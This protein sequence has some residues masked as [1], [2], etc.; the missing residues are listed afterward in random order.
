M[1]GKSKLHDIEFIDPRNL[2][3]KLPHDVKEQR[4]IMLDVMPEEVCSDRVRFNLKIIFSDVVTAMRDNGLP[5]TLMGTTGGE[6]V[7]KVADGSLAEYSKEKTIKVDYTITES[8]KNNY[9]VKLKPS[10]SIGEKKRSATASLAEGIWRKSKERGQTASYES[11]ENSLVVVDY[12]NS[13]KWIVSLPTGIKLH[14]ENLLGNLHVYFESIDNCGFQ[15]GSITIRV[16]NIDFYSG[17]RKRLWE[18]K[19]RMIHY[20][21]YIKNY[22]KKEQIETTIRFKVRSCKLDQ[23]IKK[24]PN[25]E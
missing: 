9:E 10:L 8:D 14:H 13:V 19:R 16:N 12:V 7:V 11:T 3:S 5:A 6:I 22:P 4:V 24:G 1:T 17:N 20:K 21:C 23:N 25:C 18:F 15:E 2:A